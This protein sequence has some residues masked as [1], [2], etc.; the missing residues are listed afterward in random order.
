[1]PDWYVDA[2]DITP[3]EH[4]EIQ[5]SFQDN[6][7]GAI[8]KT[9]NCPNGTTASELSRYLLRYIGDLKGVTVYVDGSRE[10]QVMYPLSS[11]EALQL[12]EVAEDPKN[13]DCTTGVC[14]V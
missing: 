14:E 13:Q 6:N 3:F 8:A 11:D 2:F 10:K 9:I 4:L 7:D 5:R 12:I 1:M